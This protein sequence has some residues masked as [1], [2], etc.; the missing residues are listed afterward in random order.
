MCTSDESSL[1]LAVLQMSSQR[2][3]KRARQSDLLGGRSI[4]RG[5]ALRFAIARPLLEDVAVDV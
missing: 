4:S 3:L 5:P 2:W 1:V